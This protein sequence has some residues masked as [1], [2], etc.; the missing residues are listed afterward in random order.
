MVSGIVEEVRKSD[1]QRGEEEGGGK[2]E[3]KGGK[4]RKREK[5]I[6]YHLLAKLKTY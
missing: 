6:I 4:R 3:G 5:K 2:E 1:Y